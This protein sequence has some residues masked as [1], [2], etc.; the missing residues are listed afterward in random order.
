MGASIA[1]Q[2]LP[3]GPV[4]E[5]LLHIVPLLLGEGIKLFASPA[6]RRIIVEPITV[7]QSGQATDLR[8]RVVNPVL[9]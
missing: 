8:F 3:E 9:R 2:N 7:G 1:Q 4:D 6:A 5:V